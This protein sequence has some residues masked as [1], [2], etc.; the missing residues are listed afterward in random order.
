MVVRLLLSSFTLLQTSLCSQKNNISSLHFLK[1]QKS[2]FCS[3]KKIISS[4]VDLSKKNL[5]P[6]SLEEFCFMSWSLP[7][8][9]KKSPVACSLW[10]LFIW[11]HLPSIGYSISLFNAH[12]YGKCMHGGSLGDSLEDAAV[13]YLVSVQILV[14]ASSAVDWSDRVELDFLRL[15]QKSTI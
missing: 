9:K 2:L 15:P 5:C 14:I 3:R 8:L 13:S 12:G 4:A 10:P 7:P 6:S 1:T 11:Q